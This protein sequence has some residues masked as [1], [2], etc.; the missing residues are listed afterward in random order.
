MVGGHGSPM[1]QQ[2]MQG[3]ATATGGRFYMVNDPTQLPQIFIKEAQL[4]SRSLIQE[5]GPWDP[6]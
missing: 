2:M 1:D 6:C 3:I 5:G 4:N